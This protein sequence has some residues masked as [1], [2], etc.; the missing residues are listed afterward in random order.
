MDIRE[1]ASVMNKS[2]E[3]V[4]DYRKSIIDK[5]SV[6]NISEAISVVM[7]QNLLGN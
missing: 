1:T 4:K 7:V 6:R 5:L 3:T 2:V